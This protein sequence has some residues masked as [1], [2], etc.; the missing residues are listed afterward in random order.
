MIYAVIPLG[1][2]EEQSMELKKR[3][4]GLQAYFDY[5]PAVY[6]VAY[7]GPARELSEKLGYGRNAENPLGT[8]V[9]LNIQTYYGFASRTLWDW[10]TVY[11]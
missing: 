3:L 7:D 5:A 11:E 10:M 1:D 9:V 4:E 6:F 8:G 2:Q